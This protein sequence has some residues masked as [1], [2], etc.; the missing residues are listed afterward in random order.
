MTRVKGEL[1]A[2]EQATLTA[3]AD[4]ATNGRG[5]R[6]ARVRGW[7]PGPE[8]KTVVGTISAGWHLP[9][10]RELG[11]VTSKAVP[12]EGRPRNPL[13][14]WRITQAG[15]NEVARRLD[16]EPRRIA[17][18]REDPMDERQIYVGR[19]AWDLLSVLQQHAE[20]L[21]WEAV[22]GE[23][24]IAFRSR[25]WHD[26]L[27][28]LLNRGFAIR[29]KRVGTPKSIVW[30]VATDAG[31]RVEATDL[32]ASR[33]TAQLRVG[34]QDESGVPPESPTPPTGMSGD[35]PPRDSGHSP[36]L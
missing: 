6:R 5:F 26:A 35:D 20:W 7:V 8:V 32:K 23:A 28:I 12:D 18:P 1:D 2:V 14:M 22:D 17:R 30:V 3:L 29:E 15:E 13:V 4:L 36:S 19:R 27:T 25:F 33:T 16:R 24:T 9:R 21:P 31:R 34:A 10:L 11:L